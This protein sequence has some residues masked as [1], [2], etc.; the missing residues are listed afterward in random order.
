MI[1]G[2]MHLGYVCAG[3]RGSGSGKREEASLSIR[4]ALQDVAR[5][6]AAGEQVLRLKPSCTR[7]R[8]YLLDIVAGVFCMCIFFFFLCLGLKAKLWERL[9]LFAGYDPRRARNI[10][11]VVS[12]CPHS[13]VL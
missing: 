2:P 13:A 5:A 9:C 12:F 11:P 8:L 7:A 3:H 10:N 1:L 4:E 6:V